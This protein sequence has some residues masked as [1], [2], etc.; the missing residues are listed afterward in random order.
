MARGEGGK[1]FWRVLIALVLP[2]LGVMMQV[3][4]GA[5]FWINVLLCF[6]FWF[7]AQL[8]AVYVI[9][10]VGPD[11]REVPDGMQTFVS[12]LVAAVLPPLGVLAKR[13]LGLPLLINVI[14]CCFFWLP[15][16]LHALWVITN[17]DRR[18]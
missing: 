15:G 6:L 1:D 3:G 8:H 13:G 12:L 16:S 7:P 10:T 5:H 4:L 11:G 9:A 14:L 18:R 17:D 2:P